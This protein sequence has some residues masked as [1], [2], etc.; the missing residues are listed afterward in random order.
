LLPFH[1]IRIPFVCY[2]KKYTFQFLLIL[3]NCYIQKPLKVNLAPIKNSL[4]LELQ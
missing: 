2:P 3:F 4:I 1:S